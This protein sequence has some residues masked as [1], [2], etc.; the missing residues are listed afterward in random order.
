MRR[1]NMPIRIA[2]VTGAGANSEAMQQARRWRPDAIF[3]KPIV[4]ELIR[5]WL[6]QSA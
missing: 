1:R 4:F 5:D 2:L 3:H 6:E